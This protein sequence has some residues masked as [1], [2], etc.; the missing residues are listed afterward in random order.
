M[1]S[2]WPRRMRAYSGSIGSLTL[3]SRSASAQ[4]CSAP[5]I[6]C[7]PAALKSTSDIEEPSPAPD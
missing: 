4:T 3:S 5:L 2:V 7:A 1:K 6:T